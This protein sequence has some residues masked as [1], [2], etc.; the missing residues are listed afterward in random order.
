[1]RILKAIGYLLAACVYTVL[2]IRFGRQGIYEFIGNRMLASWVYNLAVLVPVVLMVSQF[3]N[4]IQKSELKAK[5]PNLDRTQYLELW[6]GKLSLVV[7]FWFYFLPSASFY[8][9]VT[10]LFPSILS[11]AR[12]VTLQD[13]IILPTALFAISLI[14]IQAS[15]GTWRSSKIYAGPKVRRQLARAAIVAV[16]LAC[17]TNLAVGITRFLKIIL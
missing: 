12:T 7:A 16:S 17:T 9:I 5:Y 8:L 6:K 11:H 4:E 13:K 3:A 15:V 1:M 10:T 2:L 14:Q